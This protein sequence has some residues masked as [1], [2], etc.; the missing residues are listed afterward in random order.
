M[1]PR[2][3]GEGRGEGRDQEHSV[4]TRSGGDTMES[5]EIGERAEGQKGEAGPARAPGEW[6]IRQAAGKRSLTLIR[7]RGYGCIHVP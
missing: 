3:G 5:A 7:N 1:I 6:G 4:W 2:E